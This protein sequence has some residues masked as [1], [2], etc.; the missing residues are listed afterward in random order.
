MARR[1]KTKNKSNVKANKSSLK[2]LIKLASNVDKR[3]CNINLQ[4][5]QQ[6]Q[7]PTQF[8]LAP[9]KDYSTDYLSVCIHWVQSEQIVHVVYL[10]KCIYTYIC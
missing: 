3:N 7:K 8:F 6:K 9:I 4:S 10:C 5:K 1:K 2:V